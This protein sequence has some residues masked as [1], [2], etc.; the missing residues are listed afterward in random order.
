MYRLAAVRS[1]CSIRL[2]VQGLALSDF[3]AEVCMSSLRAVHLDLHRESDDEDVRATLVS[4]HRRVL[5]AL[6]AE[7]KERKKK[8]KKKGGGGGGGGRKVR[9]KET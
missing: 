5:T 9:K 4:G 8:K 3:D 1:S 2:Y 7:R 6:I